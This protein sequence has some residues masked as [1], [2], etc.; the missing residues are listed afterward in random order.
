MEKLCFFLFW[1]SDEFF[2]LPIFPTR[3]IEK[4]N[5]SGKNENSSFVPNL[6]G[7]TFTSFPLNMMLV[8]DFHIGLYYV[9]IIS[10]CTELF[11]FLFCFQSWKSITFCQ[12]LF[13]NLLI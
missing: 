3:D 11:L 10:F 5:R 9:K 7:K 4:L 13:W 8:T 2:C 1:L 6:I 12:V